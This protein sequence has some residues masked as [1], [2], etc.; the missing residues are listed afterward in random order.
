MAKKTTQPNPKKRVKS[1]DTGKTKS[2]VGSIY[3]YKKRKKPKRLGKTCVYFNP[4]KL[5]CES[6]NLL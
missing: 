5:T 6:S 3:T 2:V 4:D 1:Y